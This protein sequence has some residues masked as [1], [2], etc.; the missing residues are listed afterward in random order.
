[1]I[2]TLPLELILQISSFLELENY[3][4]LRSTNK[5]MQLLYKIPTLNYVPY[6]T[7]TETMRFKKELSVN[8]RVKLNLNH[9]DD[10][11][12]LF[13]V[14]NNHS[15]EFCRVISSTKSKNI[16]KKVKKN[17]YCLIIRN[18]YNP[19]MIIA[20][21]N[22]GVI[23][24]NM[25]IPNT[26]LNTF[27][28]CLFWAGSNGYLDLLSLLLNDERTDIYYEDPQGWSIIHYVCHNNQIEALR[29][30]LNDKRINLNKVNKH[31]E[32]ALQSASLSNFVDI[33]EILLDDYRTDR[34]KGR[35]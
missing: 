29:I 32:T 34:I 31:G 1:M 8:Y 28:I 24:P 7:S 14:R 5:R 16:S 17:A 22:D 33:V 3:I 9:I 11:S 6:K 26:C 25:L 27:D 19:T 13:L 10:E 18:G 30:L 35:T 15:H 21:L 12:L 23:H 2:N 4:S 20:L